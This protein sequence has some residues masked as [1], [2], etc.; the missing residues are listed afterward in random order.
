MNE[1]IECL[2]LMGSRMLENLIVLE[3]IKVLNSL[4]KFFF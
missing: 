3:F 1:S 4:E 2:E